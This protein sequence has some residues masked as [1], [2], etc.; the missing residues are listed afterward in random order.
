MISMI[1][2]K[3][4]ESERQA[5]EIKW[6]EEAMNPKELNNLKN[7]SL[8]VDVSKG[9][10]EIPYNTITEEKFSKLHGIGHSILIHSKGYVFNNDELLK[11]MGA[12]PELIKKLDPYSE[13]RR[14]GQ[15]LDLNKYYSKATIDW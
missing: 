2:N 1:K 14:L 3:F 13:S 10:F 15:S 4:L 9:S 8:Y 11:E 5:S 6:F 7:L 12:Q